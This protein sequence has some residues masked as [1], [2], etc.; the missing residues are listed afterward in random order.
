M[1]KMMMV[2]FPFVLLLLDFWPLN[3]GRRDGVTDW[4]QS[5]RLIVEK[6]PFLVGSILALFISAT[7]LHSRGA[8]GARANSGLHD[9]LRIPGNY[10]FYLGKL[11]WP[12]RLS[13]L[14]PIENVWPSVVILSAAVLV[15][16]TIVNLR[17]A[18]TK[19]WLAVGW[20]WFVG[21]LIPVVGFVPF[22]DFIVADRYTYIPSIGVTWA[23]VAA[24]EYAAGRYTI[25]RWL[26]TAVVGIACFCATLTDLPRWRNSLS[27]YDSALKIGPHYVTYS[28]RGVALL[29]AGNA[30]GAID[31][32][33]SAISLNTN[34]SRAYNNR[35]SVLSDFGKYDE[36]LQDLDKAIEHDPSFADAYDNRGNTRARKGEPQKALADYDRSLKLKPTKALTYNNRA[37]AYFQLRRFSEAMADIELCRRN[38]GQPHPGLVQALTSALPQ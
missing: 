22:G 8:F 34:F 37:S 36:A 11:F 35:G 16:I 31:D 38:G 24:T 3:R 19:P 33:S 29:R 6:I 7:A 10:V 21:V 2:T 5:R 27:L 20:L 12:T 28:N 15:V 30:Q 4:K 32:F 17:H 1:S 18:R 14:Y 9:L 25:G 26:G 13:V 23:L